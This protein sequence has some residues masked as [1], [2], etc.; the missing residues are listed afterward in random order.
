MKKLLTLGILLSMSSLACA[1]SMQSLDKSQVTK[2]MEDKTI[3]TISLTTLN[4]QMMNNAFTGYFNKNGQI[5]GKFATKPDNDPQ[6]DDGKWE[7]KSDG[8]LC[9]TWQHWQQS[10]PICVS[11]Y[12]LKNGYVFV[13][14]STKKIET[15]VLDSDVKTG[16]QMS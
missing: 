12:H 6:T 8:T 11:L 5:Q 4:D 13:N 3:T 1:A 14:N 9:V 7:V 15:I 10:K 2:A 16:N